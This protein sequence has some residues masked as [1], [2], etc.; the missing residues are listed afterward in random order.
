MP[1]SVVRTPREER[2]WEQAKQRAARQGHAGDW[3]YVMG[4]FE[5]LRTRVGGAKGRDAYRRRLR[6]NAQ[7]RL[8]FRRAVLREQG[9]ASNPQDGDGPGQVLIRENGVVDPVTEEPQGISPNPQPGYVRVYDRYGRPTRLVINPQAHAKPMVFSRRPGLAKAGA[10]ASA[11]DPRGRF[12]RD[13]GAAHRRSWDPNPPRLVL[14]GPSNTPAPPQ[15]GP[16]HTHPMA[17]SSMQVMHAISASRRQDPRAAEW[18][19]GWGFDPLANLPGRTDRPRPVGTPSVILY[20]SDP[21]IRAAVADYAAL[22][23][24]GKPPSVAIRL[25][26]Q[27]YPWAVEFDTPR[28]R[29]WWAAVRRAQLPYPPAFDLEADS[30]ADDYPRPRRAVFWRPDVANLGQGIMAPTG[31]GGAGR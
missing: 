11:R 4:V 30:E 9:V 22:L 14:R 24:A 17:E 26:S 29:D 21:A 25:L 13:R 6:R 18:P 7:G 12:I 31:S 20:K 16:G 2:L 3:A 5:R 10:Q 19:A 27:R 8:V 15:I 28:G 23:D 1:A